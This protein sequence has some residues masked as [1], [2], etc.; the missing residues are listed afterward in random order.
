MPHI[1]Y[2]L[3][4][5]AVAPQSSDECK[6]PEKIHKLVHTW[7]MSCAIAWPAAPG[8]PA[9][10]GRPSCAPPPSCN[11]LG[12]P[13][14]ACSAAA[15]SPAPNTELDPDSPDM[16]DTRLL[17]LCPAAP[18]SPA[19]P[20]PLPLLSP[21]PVASPRFQARSTSC[22]GVPTL[23]GASISPLLP[24]PAGLSPQPGERGRA[25]LPGSL[26]SSCGPG[27]GSWL[28]FRPL[29]PDRVSAPDAEV[30]AA[31]TGASVVVADA[32][33]ASASSSV[34]G[35]RAAVQCRSFRIHGL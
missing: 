8:P 11:P 32:A 3:G 33:A 22:K 2:V 17:R 24:A 28:A 26:A 5:L 12:P 20:L 6:C 21:H 10:C 23:N 18:L 30:P 13:R 31:A 1:S 25:G 34:A 27:E 15:P 9:G 19:L 4:I 14:A 29:L 7:L 16:S 35:L